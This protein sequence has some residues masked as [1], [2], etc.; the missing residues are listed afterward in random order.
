MRNIGSFGPHT[1]IDKPGQISKGSVQRGVPR[2]EDS[3]KS[4]YRK[5]VEAI[6]RTT[7]RQIWHS[8]TAFE[9]PPGSCTWQPFKSGSIEGIRRVEVKEPKVS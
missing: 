7:D 5:E 4:R 8:P 3:P 6:N 2:P 1:M 9:E